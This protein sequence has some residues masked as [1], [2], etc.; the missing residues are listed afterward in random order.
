MLKKFSVFMLVCLLGCKQAPT[1]IT[2]EVG[3]KPVDEKLVIIDT[4][5]ELDYSS[6][7]LSGSVHLNTKDFLVIKNPAAKT[8]RLDPDMLQN[9]ERLAKKGVSPAKNLLLI[10]DDIESVEIKK[11]KWFLKRLGFSNIQRSTLDEYRK[12]NPVRAPQPEPPREEVWSV[13]NSD[14]I[15]IEAEYCFV[16]W[17]EKNCAY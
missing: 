15:L 3:G 13:P 6:Y 16:T 4:R 12:K 14:L 8:K 17:T 2:E 7:H 5:S 11:W 10:T 9:I 1:K